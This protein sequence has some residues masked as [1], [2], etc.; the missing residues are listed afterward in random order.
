MFGNVWRWAGSYRHTDRNIGVPH[1]RVV[2]DVGQLLAN[3]GYWVE[4]DVFSSDEIAVRFHHRL[5][6]IHPFPNGNGR[7][8]RFSAGLLIKSLGGERFSWAQRSRPVIRSERVTCISRLS[9][10]PT[11]AI[12]AYCLSSRN[13][14]RASR[15]S[16][17]AS[18]RDGRGVIAII[19]ALPFCPTP[20]RTRSRG[21][22]AR[23]DLAVNRRLVRVAN[24]ACYGFIVYAAVLAGTALGD[25]RR[26]VSIAAII[27]VV[28]VSL[29]GLAR[30]RNREIIAA[31]RIVDHEDNKA[32]GRG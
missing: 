23:H 11:M 15:C 6:W 3:A 25:V 7:A 31:S 4:H 24:C 18:R 29:F 21:T 27:T 30:M 16:R 5:V 12:S 10:P 1:W 22:C 28:V 14:G 9:R 2:E 13:A 32:D 8:T 20:Q 26:I 19:G 17:D